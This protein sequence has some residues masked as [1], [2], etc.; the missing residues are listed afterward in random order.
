MDVNRFDWNLYMCGQLDSQ[1]IS[2]YFPVFS[3][4]LCKNVL[5]FAVICESLWEK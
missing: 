5:I 1:N 3:W 2:E 4:V